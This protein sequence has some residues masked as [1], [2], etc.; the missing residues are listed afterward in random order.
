MLLRVRQNEKTFDPSN[1]DDDNNKENHRDAFSYSELI[2][3]K[4]LKCRIKKSGSKI[5]KEYYVKW[6][7]FSR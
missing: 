6:K 4:I 3:E 2:P 1:M 5:K 7:G